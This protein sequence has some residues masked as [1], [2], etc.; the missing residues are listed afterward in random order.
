[1]KKSVR[2]AV[3]LGLAALMSFSVL[4]ALTGC[5]KSDEDVIRTGLTSELDKFKDP[6]SDSW[7]DFSTNGEFASMGLEEKDVVS[8]WVEGFGYTIDSVTVD[9]NNAEVKVSITCKQLNPIIA[10]MTDKVANDESF[11]GLTQEEAIQK[12]GQIF[13][14]D[15]KVA[16]TT[17]TQITI[18]CVKNGDTWTEGT[19]AISAYQ[20]ALLGATAA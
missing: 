13:L 14:A 15:L 19:G 12:A 2:K 9:G 7:T 17:T 5:G 10:S 6:T 4:F 8:A 11:V 3:L 1:M 18:P 16:Q 20:T